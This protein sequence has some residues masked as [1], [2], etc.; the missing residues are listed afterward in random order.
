MYSFISDPNFKLGI[1]GGGQLG[2]MLILSTADYDIYTKV[3]DPDPMCSSST[4]CNEFVCGSFN[5][6]DDVV[7]FGSDCT[8]VTVEIEHVNTDALRELKKRGVAVH[9]DPD[10]LDTIKDKGLQKQFYKQHGLPT[11]D[12]ILVSGEDEIRAKAASGEIKFPFVQK[13]R[14]AGYDGKG[15]KVVKSA[16]D[17]DSLLPGPSVI[18]EAVNIKKEL[19][20]IVAQSA[21]NSEPVAFDVVDME[22]SDEA[23]LVEFLFCPA[24]VS[25]D[26]KA[27]A[28]HLA[29]RTLKAYNINGLL[30]VELFLDQNDELLINEVAPRPHNSGHHTIDS[31][32][33]S[34]FEQHW[35][36][37]LNVPLGN[38]ENRSASVMVNILGDGGYSGAV[39]Y[40]GMKEALSTPG[41]KFHIYGK[42][43]TKPFRKMGHFTVLSDQLEDAVSTARRIKDQLNVIA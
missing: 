12:F 36:S 39:K 41:V 21:M 22:F 42:K 29:K 30:A 1:L 3:L 31:C 13:T 18:E 7:A 33:T 5:N 14:E 28:L 25:E 4:F 19:A 6:Y 35:R 27:R 11:S 37:V 9:P 10:A 40:M 24:Q 23:N 15:V 32:V 17:L 20:V 8:V 34:Q 26:I 38:T 43:T 16:A 2:K